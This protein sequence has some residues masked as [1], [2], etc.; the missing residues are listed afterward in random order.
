MLPRHEQDE[1]VWDFSIPRFYLPVPKRP[2]PR[3][4]IEKVVSPLSRLGEA[5]PEELQG[6]WAYDWYYLELLD[7]D[8][9]LRPLFWLSAERLCEHHTDDRPW[10]RAVG[11]VR[12]RAG[13]ERHLLAMDYVNGTAGD[14]GA[15]DLNDRDEWR[16]WC[17]KTFGANKDKWVEAGDLSYEPQGPWLQHLKF[18]ADLRHAQT[19]N[20]LGTGEQGS[21][22]HWKT[23]F[24]SGLPGVYW[25]MIPIY[26]A[27][28]MGH[29]WRAMQHE[30]YVTSVFNLGAKQ[31]QDPELWTHMEKRFALPYQRMSRYSYYQ[32]FREQK[33]A[34][35]IS[36][37]KTFPEI[38]VLLVE[39]GLHPLS[40]ELYPPPPELSGPD[41]YDLK[42][43]TARRTAA[44]IG[45]RLAK[46]GVIPKRPGGRPKKK[47]TT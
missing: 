37:G 3:N 23:R 8:R 14:G 18:D 36:E 6:E 10:R 46:R 22:V 40:R 21:S 31:E 45:A 28:A 15:R 47:S 38:G 5:H 19:V 27:R 26:D 39:K 20:P 41:A 43:E 13:H 34:D 44:T 1:R 30:L 42:V 9:V 29:L 2:Q 33:V 4:W 12:E 7:H 24:A 25:R 16:R 32:R 11:G 17:S 35:W